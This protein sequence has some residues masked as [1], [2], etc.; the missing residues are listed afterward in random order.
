MIKSVF[1]V[2]SRRENVFRTLTDF[3]KYVQWVPG[4]EVCKVVGVKGNLTDVEV[5]INS[6]KRLELGLQFEAEPPNFV[7]FRMTS[8]KGIKEYSGTYRLMDAT[9]R[10]G[11]VLIA[12]LE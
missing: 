10:S 7:R 9:D 6:M 2:E 8:G 11:T 3:A 5:V 12:E 4:C 1:H